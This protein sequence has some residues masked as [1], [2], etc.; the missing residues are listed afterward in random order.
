MG[1]IIGVIPARMTST[2]L[3]GKPL[4]LIEG[5]PLIAWVV[6]AARKAQS[7]DRI[8]VAGD[9]AAIIRAA[10]AAGAE[11]RLTRDDHPSGTDRVAEVAAS[12]PASIYIN[13]QGDEPEIAGG[14]IDAVAALLENDPEL[15][16]A[17][18]AVELSEVDDFLSPHRVK[19]VCDLR[20][21]ALYFSRAPIPHSRLDPGEMSQRL[22]MGA[23]RAWG[24]VGIYGYRRD[25]LLRLV[26]EPPSPLEI[27]E[28]LE[29]LRAL[30]AGLKIGVVL[31]DHAAAGIDTPEDLENFRRRVGTTEGE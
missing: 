26:E 5:R 1:D 3:P 29:Q 14:T 12:V 28:R 19:V 21:R 9:D 13:I 4:A 22:P 6:D 27:C 23:A 8:V 20:G 10:E 25:A 16:M 2:R 31:V 30:Q 24:H 18:A 15:D 7:L 11:A 17:T